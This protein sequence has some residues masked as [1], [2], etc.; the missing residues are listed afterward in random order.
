MATDNNTEALVSFIDKI[1][2]HVHVTA[3]DR[4]SEI[5]NEFLRG[6]EFVAQYP[7]TVTIYGGTK[8]QEGSV[9]YEKARVLA[10]KIVEQTRC[11]VVTGGGPGIMEA[12]NR[13][14]KEANGDSIG[15]TIKLPHE[16]TTN[17]YVTASVN[18]YYFFVRRFIL[19]FTAKCFVF[20]PGG[21]GTLDE[22][23]EILTLRQTHKISPVP[24][25]LFGTEYWQPLEKLFRISLLEKYG[26]IRPEDLLIYNITDDEDG[27]IEMVKKAHQRG[28]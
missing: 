24:I 28:Q 5:D 21:F 4:V 13:G 22:F 2:H 7:K 11:A 8:I 14:A 10:K 18:F 3:E 15:I 19:S 23:F 20:F 25:V 27:I 26:T 12:A 6:F 9:Y 1:K 16:Q 17:K